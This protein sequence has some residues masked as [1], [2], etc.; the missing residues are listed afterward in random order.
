MKYFNFVSVHERVNA[1]YYAK[2]AW[3]SID[4]FITLVG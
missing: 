1:L 2:M 3:K 4:S